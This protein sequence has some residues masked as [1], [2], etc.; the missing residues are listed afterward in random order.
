MN[1]ECT[2]TSC[3]VPYQNSKHRSRTL[4]AEPSHFAGKQPQVAVGIVSGARISFSLNA[5]YMAKGSLITGEQ[6][7]EFF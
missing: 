1:A 7:V 5:P 6:Q 2:P 3:R 4:F